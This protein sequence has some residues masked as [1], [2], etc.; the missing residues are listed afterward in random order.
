MS[1]KG[2]Q[3]GEL[4]N[5]ESAAAPD[6]TKP[7]KAIG[8]GNMLEGVKNIFNYALTEGERTGIAKGEKIGL[9]KGS[10]ITFGVCGALYLIPKG[11]K[12]VKKKIADRKAHDEMGEKIHAAFSEELTAGSDEG[13]IGDEEIEISEA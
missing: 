7:L 6:V 11:V 2:S 5:T 10:A 13:G 12:Y 9:A 3:I 8:D 1:N 4:L